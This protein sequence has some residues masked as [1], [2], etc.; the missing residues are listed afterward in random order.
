MTI[1]DAITAGELLEKINST[2]S[3]LEKIDEAIETT[4]ENDPNSSHFSEVKLWDGFY[5]RH[6]AFSP[7]NLHSIETFNAGVKKMLQSFRNDA[8]ARHEQAIEELKKIGGAASAKAPTF[9][10]SEP[11]LWLVNSDEPDSEWAYAWAQV[12]N[13]CKLKNHLFVKEHWNYLST[14]RHSYNQKGSPRYA[15][16]HVW[17]NKNFEFGNESIFPASQAFNPEIDATPAR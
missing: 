12:E 13:F 4:D 17:A 16:C 2:Q 5:G 10:E 11:S 9:E 14:V 6:V 7:K 15:Y 8:L 3:Q 1:D